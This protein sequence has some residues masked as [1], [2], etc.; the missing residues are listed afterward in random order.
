MYV[1]VLYDYFLLA[2]NELKNLWEEYGILWREGYANFFQLK[3]LITLLWR[4]TY[5]LVHPV[6][7]KTFLESLNIQP[8]VRGLVKFKP[9]YVMSR[10]FYPIL[11]VLPRCILHQGGGT[12][13]G[14]RCNIHV[15]SC[16]RKN[17]LTGWG[18][19]Y[20]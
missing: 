14:Q 10:S 7:A 17:R 6:Q 4:S 19:L 2:D 9:I 3:S 8:Y 12:L 13:P 20:R 11:I 15:G 1:F 16:I 18:V 5:I